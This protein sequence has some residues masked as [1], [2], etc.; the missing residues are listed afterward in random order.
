[1]LEMSSIRRKTRLFTTHLMRDI[2]SALQLVD[3]VR[4]LPRKSEGSRRWS[5]S[6][7]HPL[8]AANSAAKQAYNWI[9]QPEHCAETVGSNAVLSPV[10]RCN[11]LEGPI[12]TQCQLLCG[13]ANTPPPDIPASVS[14]LLVNV[15]KD[16][17]DE[18]SRNTGD[19]TE[20][21]LNE[22]LRV[23]PFIYESPLF[24][25]T[26]VQE[27]LRFKVTSKTQPGNSLVASRGKGIRCQH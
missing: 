8:P 14:T 6:A 2:S 24:R 7:Q 20:R 10:P 12:R 26:K 27:R 5:G 18:A 9:T 17:R 11:A 21:S 19:R 16:A 25:H 1:M 4:V 15:A 22:R 3:C 23:K 13:S